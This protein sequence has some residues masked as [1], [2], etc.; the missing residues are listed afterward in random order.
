V[1][2][3][4]AKFDN[5]QVCGCS[6]MKVVPGNVSTIS[7]DLQNGNPVTLTL[8]DLITGLDA[9]GPLYWQVY[10]P[11]CGTFSTNPTT[12]STVTYTNTS[13]YP[14]YFTVT[15]S[16]SCSV[17][18]HPVQYVPQPYVIDFEAVEHAVISDYW[19]GDT[20]RFAVVEDPLDASN[21]ALF[22]ANTGSWAY[23]SIALSDAAA[24]PFW[25]TTDT[26]GI[27]FDNYIVE[28]DTW[29]TD[30]R[31]H[32]SEGCQSLLLFRY[33]DLTHH[34]R[35]N[36]RNAKTSGSWPGGS[37]PEVRFVRYAATWD[38]KYGKEL[39]P[40]YRLPYFLENTKYHL[41]AR[42]EGYD[43]EMWVTDAGGTEIDHFTLYEDEWATGPPGLCIEGDRSGFGAYF[44]NFTITPIP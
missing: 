9:S 44:D 12:G 38:C 14:D 21:K 40:G 33:N 13:G 5:I 27:A 35:F 16:D 2:G 26:K 6:N 8:K 17:V 34:Y 10:P 32:Y 15:A 31:A 41:K 30:D 23:H 3:I 28:F 11:V 36:I 24:E 43:Y 19:T 29:F 22:R 42:V 4:I 20:T 7:D 37:G 39:S 1:K 18:Y 25:K